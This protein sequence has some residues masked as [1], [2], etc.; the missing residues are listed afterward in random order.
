MRLLRA[1]V[2]VAAATGT[3]LQ[4]VVAAV[5]M[6]AGAYSLVL[7]FDKLT[8]RNLIEQVGILLCVLDSVEARYFAAIVPLLNCIRLLIYGLSLVTDEGLIKSVTRK[9]KPE[10]L[11]RGPL[12]YVLVLLFCVVFFWRESPVGITSLAMMSGGDGFADIMGRRYGSLK[13]PYNRKKSWIGSISMFIFGFLC[14]IM[15]LY[16]FSTLGYLYMD[17]G[18]TVKKVAVIALAGAVV[19]SLPLSEIIDDNITVPLISMLAGSLVFS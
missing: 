18:R 14:S 16:Y 9:G 2:A 10:E 15:M 13:L 8:K 19:E 11:L 1:D 6:T 5:L 4:D 7:F 12:Y 3:V 17:W